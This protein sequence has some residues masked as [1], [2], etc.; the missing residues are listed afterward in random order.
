MTVAE[1]ARTLGTTSIGVDG[2]CWTN[3]RGYGRHARALLRA[4]VRMESR[5][6]YTVVVDTPE[7]EAS[8]PD[9]VT[10]RVVATG[11]STTTAAAADGHRS[12]GDLWRIGRALS[13]IDVDVL[14]FPTVYSYVP[15][16]SRAKK[17]VVIHDVIVESFPEL[18]LPRP[19]ARL[20]WRLKVGLARWQADALAT[21]SEHSRRGIVER[22]KVP[23]D[24]VFVVG[25]AADPVFR[26]LEDPR[27][28]PALARFDLGSGRRSMV[29]VG[30]FGPHKNL[31]PLIEVFAR[32]ARTP[33]F[34]DV[35]LFMVGEFQRE[36]FHSE[37]EGLRRRVDAL[38]VG[39]RVVFTGYLSDEDLVVL[40]NLASVLVLP[41]LLEGFGL[42]AVEAA[43]CGCPVVATT[44]SPLPG[45]LGE[46]GLYVDPRD[47]DE[48]EAALRRVLGSASLRRT[49]RAAGLARAGE[50]T[51]EAAATQMMK[52]VERVVDRQGRTT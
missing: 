48:L 4:L 12:A 49:M 33:Q 44:A 50:L 52:I 18:T 19:D 15:I 5:A 27:P 45:L 36:A 23:P 21:V 16:F 11:R 46:G 26:V 6:R 13:A 38:G 22:F 29:Y 34:R 9:G 35:R 30:G 47:N 24:R 51:W 31:G 17:I 28:G 39:D 25:E 40:L 1:R 14:L 42:P 8:L 37:F 10:A 2:T 3:P 41:S 32:I 43:A 7:A 20:L